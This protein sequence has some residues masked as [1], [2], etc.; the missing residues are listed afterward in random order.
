MLPGSKWFHL[1]MDCKLQSRNGPRMVAR[2][3][4]SL[5]RA[6]W[7]EGR[8]NG[9]VASALPTPG[10][11]NFDCR[12]LNQTCNGIVSYDPVCSWCVAFLNNNV[13][14]TATPQTAVFERMRPFK[15]LRR[16]SQKDSS[17][18][19]SL[20]L[21]SA[22]DLSADVCETDL[23][24]RSWTWLVRTMFPGMLWLRRNKQSNLRRRRASDL[25]FG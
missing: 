3:P 13:H 1:L 15:G 25:G 8:E 21:R 6:L 16:I 9:P 4:G 19:R 10:T 22:A 24:R 20:L 23:G 17:S 18:S 5:C 2:G 11:E 14:R 7:H 12:S